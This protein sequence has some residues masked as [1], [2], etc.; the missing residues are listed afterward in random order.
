MRRK[1]G[2]AGEPGNQKET[3]C[4]PG[5]GEVASS[6]VREAEGDC[7]LP[8]KRALTVFCQKI[9]QEWVSGA[10]G[11]VSGHLGPTICQA[12]ATAAGLSRPLW[13]IFVPA[14]CQ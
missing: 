7:R 13:T 4:G 11:E 1:G 10:R 6:W 14:I 5:H 9:W 8:R 2:V 12:G 3:R